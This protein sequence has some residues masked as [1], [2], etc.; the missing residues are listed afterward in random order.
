MA[1]KSIVH[2]NQTDVDVLNVVLSSS[3]TRVRS[4]HI[5]ETLLQRGVSV[6][7]S[8]VARSIRFLVGAGKLQAFGK[9]RGTTYSSLVATNDLEV[10]DV[11]TLSS[12]KYR[13]AGGPTVSQIVRAVFNSTN[14]NDKM[15]PKEIQEKA[16]RLFPQQNLTRNSFGQVFSKMANSGELM[17]EGLGRARRYWRGTERLSGAA[18]VPSLESE[19]RVEVS[20]SE[21]VASFG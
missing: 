6:D 1:R 2:P 19:T 21:D 5:L 16:A 12:G 3:E 11:S 10:V 14:P 13:M 20:D 18:E 17:F 7:K 8:E 9:G 15:S 4:A